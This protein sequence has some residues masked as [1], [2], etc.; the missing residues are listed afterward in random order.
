VKIGGA[1]EEV[2]KLIEKMLWRCD[3]MKE[4]KQ[5]KRGTSSVGTRKGYLLREFGEV[6]NAG[7]YAA[8]S[9]TMI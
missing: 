9:T 7:V 4:H 8:Y 5:P 2:K 6:G 3:I 1:R